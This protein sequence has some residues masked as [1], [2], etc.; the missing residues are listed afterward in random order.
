MR[1]KIC[2][3][4]SKNLYFL[5]FF[6]AFFSVEVFAQSARSTSFDDRPVCESS[7]G[8][9]REFG[10][11]CVDGCTSKLDQFAVCSAAITYGCDC[12]T[13]R[14]W[15]GDSC[16]SLKSYKK[17]FDEEQEE[18]RKNTAEAKKKR[19]EESKQNEQA[20]MQKFVNQVTSA[21]SQ[22]SNDPKNTILSGNNLAE[23]YKNAP[24]PQAVNAAPNQSQQS[25]AQI[26]AQE[27]ESRDQ[28][29]MLPNDE[30]PPFFTTRASAAR[31]N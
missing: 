2:D 12:G 10:N 23:F 25:Q 18:E 16:V 5:R 27:H 28:N 4:F 21:D 20:I 15:D 1:D 9:W 29:G 3:K 19:K 14:C 11:A 22:Q 24:K 8:I 13:G 26:P 7:K 30:V 31:H 17:I 6:S